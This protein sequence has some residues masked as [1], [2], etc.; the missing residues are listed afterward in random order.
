M[1]TLSYLQEV[2]ESFWEYAK[3]GV[4]INYTIYNNYCSHCELAS[5]QCITHFKTLI[6]PIPSLDFSQFEAP[7]SVP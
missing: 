5:Y 7:S 4:L 1:E 6:H 3:C 2:V